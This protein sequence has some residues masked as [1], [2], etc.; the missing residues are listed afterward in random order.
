MEVSSVINSTSAKAEQDRTKLSGD[1]DQFLRLLTTQLQNQDPLSPMDSTEF[2]NQLVSFSQV[3]QQIRT[4][5]YLN[6]QLTLQ[7]LNLTSLGLGFIGLDI[8]MAGSFFRAD[9]TKPSSMSYEMPD[10]VASASLSIIDENG[11]VVYSQKPD[12]GAGKHV[13]LWDGKNNEGQPVPAGTYELRVGALDAKQK[14]LTVTTN[15]P[16]HVDGIESGEDGNIVLL[17]GDRKVA[18]TDVRR[19]S[20]SAG[21]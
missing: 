18:I 14:S 20:E 12:T 8:E 7:S 2:T 19:A 15:V 13:L 16:G 6:K 5:D 21:M 11:T 10:G 1:F 3:E 17:V 9:G 4:N